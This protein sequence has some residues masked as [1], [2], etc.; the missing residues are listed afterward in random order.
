[1][2]DAATCHR[3][4]W[5]ARLQ[6]ITRGGAELPATPT[7]SGVMLWASSLASQRRL[8]P[9]RDSD[10]HAAVHRL[11]PDRARL[12]D[13][14]PTDGPDA[15]GVRPRPLGQAGDVRGAGLDPHRTR[16]PDPPEGLLA[17]RLERG[18]SARHRRGLVLR[19]ASRPPCARRGRR[20]APDGGDSRRA[21]NWELGAWGADRCR[22]RLL[23]T[24]GWACAC[25]R[26]TWP[27]R[28]PG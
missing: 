2:A 16:R 4:V 8:L 26:P 17:R 24:G 3:S 1:M 10:R 14:P 23:A 12:R 18:H 27:S 13:A 22:P 7:T 19:R 28:H 20:R 5:C 21:L 25:S 9:P 6:R 15:G 11:L